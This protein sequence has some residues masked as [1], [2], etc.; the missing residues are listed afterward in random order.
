MVMGEQ[1]HRPAPALRS[2]GDLVNVTGHAGD[3]AELFG[4]QLGEECVNDFIA[5][6]H[7]LGELENGK[8]TRQ[9]EGLERDVLQD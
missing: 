2:D 3:E 8:R 6:A 7:A 4:A 9:V 5:E 1:F